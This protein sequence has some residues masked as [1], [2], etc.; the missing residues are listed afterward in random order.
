MEPGPP[1]AT[2]S[3]RGDLLRRR[4]IGILSVVVVHI[5]GF[6]LLLSLTPD[7]L[8]K[9]AP[10][11]ENFTLLSYSEKPAP[12]PA[13]R[14][15]A[16]R[17]QTRPVTKPTTPPVTPLPPNMILMSSEQFRATDIGDIHPQHADA[18]TGNGGAGTE[19]ASGPGEGPGGQKLYPA[20]WYR[21]PTTAEMA[22]Y[23]KGRNQAG[24]AMI[25]CRTIA[26]NRVED[27]QELQESPS[28]SGLAG[29]LRQ[30]AWQFRIR[31]PRI[32]GKPQLGVWVRILFDFQVGVI[33]APR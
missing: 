8:R 25:A 24:W 29:A 9:A 22:F 32:G 13:A 6:L 17:R 28:G 14:S 18:G 2:S 27:C 10:A 12:K 30:A 7:V 20:D 1:T 23:L 26:D 11:L 16:P 3:D 19:V 21:E 31:P 5:L 33:R 4:T 15:N